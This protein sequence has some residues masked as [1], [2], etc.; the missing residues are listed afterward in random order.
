MENSTL[1]SNQQKVYAKISLRNNSYLR[2]NNTTY[3]HTPF[4]TK[5]THTKKALYQLLPIESSIQKNWIELN[6][7]FNNR[8]TCIWPIACGL[9]YWFKLVSFGQLANWHHSSNWEKFGKYKQLGK[10]QATGEKLE[11]WSWSIITY[12]LYQYINIYQNIQFIIYQYIQLRTAES[13]WRGCVLDTRRSTP[14]VKCATG[15]NY[16]LYMLG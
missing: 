12:T 2:F 9:I 11:I 7:W 3:I 14:T 16:E 15:L 4:Q 5:Q 8:V 10:I 1:F 6:W 13:E